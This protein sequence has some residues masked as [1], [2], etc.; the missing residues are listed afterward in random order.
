MSDVEPQ[1]IL[2]ERL[3]AFRTRY[4]FE[5]LIGNHGRHVLFHAFAAKEVLAV[6]DGLHRERVYLVTDVASEPVLSVG[7][8]AQILFQLN[9]MILRVF[10]ISFLIICIHEGPPRVLFGI[11]VNRAIGA[12]KPWNNDSTFFKVSI[13]TNKEAIKVFDS[14]CLYSGW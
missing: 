1:G 8:L 5:S 3:L 13:L 14:S 11:L 7:H 9:L 10:I 2:A 4:E 12:D 6:K